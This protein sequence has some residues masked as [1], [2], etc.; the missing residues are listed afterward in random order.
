MPVSL[1]IK[2]V[3]LSR[4]SI[5]LI[6][7]LLLLNSIFFF[8]QCN[9]LK[10]NTL[11]GEELKLY[12]EDFDAS[13]EAVLENADKMLGNPLFSDSSSFVFK[14]LKVTKD[15]YA[16]LTDIAPIF[17]ENRGIMTVLGYRL[18]GLFM[19]LFKRFPALFFPGY[20]RFSRFFMNLPSLS[21]IIHAYT[22]NPIL[23]FVSF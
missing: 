1:E 5:T 6:C 3:L 18:T 21:I 20:R 16:T 19:L 2:R 11:T 9:G 17:G 15:D 8:Y 23:Y 22:A 13:V 4:K 12:T 10:T 14:N 7:I